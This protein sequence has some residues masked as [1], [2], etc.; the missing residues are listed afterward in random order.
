[1]ICY[2]RHGHNE[3]D[4]PSYT[5]PQMYAQ[6]KE[7]RSIRKLYTESLVNKGDL[8]LKEA[9]EALNQYNNMLDTA[10][11]ETRESAPPEIKIPEKIT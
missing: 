4:E 8:T 5:Q 9:E 7:K 3:G 2:R 10:F 6:I 1:M 11:E